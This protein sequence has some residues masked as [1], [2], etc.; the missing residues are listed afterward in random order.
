MER[1]ETVGDCDGEM[2][3]EQ[4]GDASQV[5]ERNCHYDVLRRFYY[6]VI[7]AFLGLPCTPPSY[8]DYC[9]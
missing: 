8:T 7:P 2:E 1:E 9:P 4:A 6:T 3:M 5:S